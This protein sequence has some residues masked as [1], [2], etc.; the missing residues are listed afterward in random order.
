MEISIKI[1]F[2]SFTFLSLLILMGCKDYSNTIPTIEIVSVETENDTTI[3]VGKVLDEGIGK[4]DYIGFCYNQKGDPGLLENQILV[5][6]ISSENVFYTSIIELKPDSTYYFKAFASNGISY[7]ESEA[8]S[9]MIPLTSAPNVPCVLLNDTVYKD[10]YPYNVNVYSGEPYSA[11]GNWGIRASCSPD[12]RLKFDFHDIPANGI[13][14]SCDHISF[15]LDNKNVFV[16]IEVGFFMDLYSINSGGKIYV[17]NI[18]NDSIIVSFCNL[19]Y[20]QSSSD[21]E[22]KGKLICD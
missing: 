17:E 15:D 5:E 4:L 9:F 20:T 6:S 8:M 11:Q 7:G 14:T 3:I 16:S 19:T 10:G 12:L 2:I 21:I 1:K 22:L 18:T 13:Y